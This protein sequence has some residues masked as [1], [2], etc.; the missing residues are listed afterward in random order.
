LSGPPSARRGYERAKRALDLAIA[1][2]AALVLS[3]VIA[4]LAAAV[5]IESRGSVFFRQERIGRDGR[6]FGIVKLRTLYDESPEDPADYLISRGDRRITRVGAFLRRW[7]LD[8]LPQLWNIIR[9]DMSMVGPRPTLAYQVEKYTDFQRRRLEVAPGV[10]GWAQIHG[11]NKLSWPERIELDVW[12]V[13][14]RSFRL[15]LEILLR[16]VPLLFHSGS[17]YG[18]IQGDWG[19]RAGS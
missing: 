14:H 9:G 10:T 18:D 17:V 8:E 12:Y 4:G 6:A 19:E 2:P 11:R 15:D 16:T 13:D 7:S 3:P 1:V 5:R